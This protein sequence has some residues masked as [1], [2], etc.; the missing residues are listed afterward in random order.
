MSAA[1]P[2]QLV[3]GASQIGVDSFSQIK[4]QRVVIKPNL[5]TTYRPN[6]VNRVVFKIP[7]FSNSFLDTSK[8]FLSFNVAYETS[9]NVTVKTDQCRLNNGS[10]VFQR[11]TLKTSNG[12]VIDQIDNYHILSQIISATKPYSAAISP[13][14]GYDASSVWSNGSLLPD[15]CIAQKFSTTGIPIVQ[16]I[17]MGLLSRHTR[18]W[19][20]LSLMNGGGFAFELELLLSDNTA[21]LSQEGV[22]SDPVY[23]LANV[24]YN[25]EIRTLDESLC[26]KFN[27]I[28]CS[29]DEIRIGFKTMHSHTALLNSPKNIVKIHESATSL[30]R[31][32]NVF[33]NS[34]VMNSLSRTSAYNLIGGVGSTG[35]RVITRYNAR[36]GSMWLFNDYVS[37]S[38]EAEGNAVTISHVRN[39]LNAQDTPL[40]M[41]V[42]DEATF[43]PSARHYVQCLD[44]Q[45]SGNS[46]FVNGISTSTPLEMFFDL[47]S[48]YASNDVICYSFAEISYDL[49]IKGGMV[50]YEEVRP[51][52]NSVYA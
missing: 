29:G 28:A 39:A 50:H 13:Q 37:E 49:V 44:F 6:G 35:N 33:L 9:T 34:T 52:S 51:G 22:V 18:K 4:P 2:Q 16:Y 19:L 41:Q 40:V 32:W 48:A 24:A 45:Y 30:D 5:D 7:S 26:R 31:V 36:V 20:P 21:V 43:K 23:R 12:L 17:N 8:S 11:L 46:G 14:E 1:I 42:V 25:M 10:P 38:S 27:Q 47:P 15:S 3:P